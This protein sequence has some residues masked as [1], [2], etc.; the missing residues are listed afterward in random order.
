MAPPFVEHIMQSGVFIVTGIM[1]AP[2][3]WA[4]TYLANYDVIRAFDYFTK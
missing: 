4:H 1:Y 3:L 2:T